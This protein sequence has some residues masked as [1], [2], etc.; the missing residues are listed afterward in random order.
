MC[1]QPEH[2]AY[3]GVQETLTGT[4]EQHSAY[5][6]SLGQQASDTSA[7][8]SV[9]LQALQAQHSA[10]LSQLATQHHTD[11]TFLHQQ[12]K[13]C[14]MLL[15][16]Q[17][18]SHLAIQR[19]D[20]KLMMSQLATFL[21]WQ[22]DD[23]V[24]ELCASHDAAFS[25]LHT[26]YEQQLDAVQARMLEQNVDA[27]QTICTSSDAAAEGLNACNVELTQ[28]LS[29]LHS[30]QLEVLGMTFR[31]D[32]EDV[33]RNHAQDWA[34][35]QA[36]Y[37]ARMA[38]VNA[39]HE[40]ALSETMTLATQDSQLAVEFQLTEADTRHAAELEALQARQK[41]HL[42]EISTQREQDQA[43]SLSH[44]SQTLEQLSE[45]HAQ[46]VDMVETMWAHKQADQHELHQQ[47]LLDLFMQHDSAMTDLTTSFREQLEAA[48]AQHEEQLSQMS[49]EQN[50]VQ[51][52]LRQ[53]AE[54]ECQ[55]HSVQLVN[56]QLQAQ[57]TEHKL[58]AELSADRAAIAAANQRY[59]ELQT[60]LEV[61]SLH[62]GNTVW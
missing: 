26:Q 34:D 17:H 61:R 20:H 8:H 19:E 6:R 3:F 39:R 33:K 53:Q 51:A 60:Q 5:V 40:A 44:L 11:V 49:C 15:Q 24:L 41:E 35:T 23:L 13:D 18:T 22:R 37:H 28:D 7:Q 46:S 48:E 25:S 10:E 50:A 54:S 47:Q 55:Q 36:D 21:V 56:L 12:L 9:Q 42:A 31:S 62:Q 2:T 45:E 14:Q 29:Q 27:L 30:T 16:E 32:L 52:G 4:E 58:R 1:V 57:Q 38:D 43:E 59:Q